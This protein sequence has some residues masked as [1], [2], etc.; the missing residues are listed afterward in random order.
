MVY[1][2]YSNY[3][4]KKKEKRIQLLCFYGRNFLLTTEGYKFL[5]LCFIT[6]STIVYLHLSLYTHLAKNS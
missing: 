6:G 2:E 4:L 3:F 5:Y 1:I